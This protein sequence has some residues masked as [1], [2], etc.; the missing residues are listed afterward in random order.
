M[1]APMASSE[2]S[3]IGRP[4]QARGSTNVTLR[5]SSGPKHSSPRLAAGLRNVP[6]PEDTRSANA[7]LPRC[8]A[9]AVAR[10]A[11]VIG[12][13]ERTSPIA[14]WSASISSAVTSK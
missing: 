10:S 4:S 5:P 11:R 8:R 3:G 1:T 2:G 12:V 13:S 9:R 6:Q 14:S 7:S